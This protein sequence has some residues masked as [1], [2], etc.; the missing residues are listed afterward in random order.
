L[1]HALVEP[2][3]I[4]KAV[5]WDM[6]PAS[7]ISEVCDII[8]RW[9]LTLDIVRTPQSARRARKQPRSVPVP[10]TPQPVF[11]PHPAAQPNLPTPRSSG[12]RGRGNSRGRGGTPRANVPS[13]QM[14][15]TAATPL[16]ALNPIRNPFPTPTY[17]DFFSS[18]ASSRTFTPTA[19][20]FPMAPSSS[21]ARPP[22]SRTQP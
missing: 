16:P 20:R 21:P 14:A 7:D 9:R 15:S 5:P 17:D 6:A 2:K 1:K 19:L 3:H 4:L 18:L 12:N 22:F 10:I 8:A 11:T 13:R